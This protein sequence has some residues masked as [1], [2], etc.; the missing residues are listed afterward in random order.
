MLT[1]DVTRVPREC[2]C[3][4]SHFTI[5][6]DI[7][8]SEVD[9]L[10]ESKLQFRYATPNRDFPVVLDLRRAA[11]RE[12][13]RALYCFDSRSG[14]WLVANRSPLVAWLSLGNRPL[15][16]EDSGLGS[17]AFHLQPSMMDSR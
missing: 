6:F 17:T 12:L 1:I 10:V 3:G 11:P 7:R 4:W 15:V 9:C 8:L 13:S 2:P 5:K 14:V 16:V